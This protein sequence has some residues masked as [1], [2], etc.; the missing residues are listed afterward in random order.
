MSLGDLKDGLDGLVAK[1]NVEQL[2][3]S[4]IFN[5]ISHGTVGNV[6]MNSYG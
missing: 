5:V 3:E 1:V 6:V 4:C 2:R